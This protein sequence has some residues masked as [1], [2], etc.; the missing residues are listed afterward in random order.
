MANHVRVDT[1]DV[2]TV[3]WDAPLPDGERLVLRHAASGTVRAGRAAGDGRRWT[4]PA[5]GLDTGRWEACIEAGSIARPLLT[6]DPGFSL[7]GLLAYAERPRDRAVRVTRAPDGRVGLAVRAVVPHAEVR[8][9]HPGGG[10]IRVTGRLAYTGPR[11]ADAR[12]VAVAR[13]TGWRVAWSARVEGTA[14][15]VCAPID[16]LTAEPPAIWDLWLDAAGVRARLATRL[17]DAPG[18]RGKVSYPRQFAGDRSVRPYY[19][20]R[21]ELAFACH[22][23]ADGNR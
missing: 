21:D 20:A 7:D 14:F 12:L 19:T 15:R 3:G 10:E 11:P 8:A 9:V 2:L 17:D 6:D 4:L 5:A 16:V 22:E 23:R 18:K 13:G 1:D